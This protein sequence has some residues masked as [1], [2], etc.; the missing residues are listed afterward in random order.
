VGI[1][2]GLAKAAWGIRRSSR[3]AMNITSV[4]VGKTQNN[5]K[6]KEV[7]LKELKTGEKHSPYLPLII[8]H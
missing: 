5:E 2:I 1:E 7:Y 8:L 3:V 6:R 4:L